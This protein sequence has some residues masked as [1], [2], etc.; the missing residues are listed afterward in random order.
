VAFYRIYAH[1]NGGF[2][3]LSE[4]LNFKV[5]ASALKVWFFGTSAQRFN[6]AY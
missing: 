6:D 3:A 4:L 1:R 5:F 2:S